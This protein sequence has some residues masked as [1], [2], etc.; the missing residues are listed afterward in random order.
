VSPFP[1]II[2]NIAFEKCR[3]STSKDAPKNKL[4]RLEVSLSEA[5][6]TRSFILVT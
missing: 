3:H 5:Q 1:N 6:K 2:K 4:K